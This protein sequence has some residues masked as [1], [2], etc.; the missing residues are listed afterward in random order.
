M[1]Q[2]VQ[3]AMSRLG[4][5]QTVTMRGRV[6]QV[7][8]LT[9]AACGP[10]A[11]LG[12]L[13]YLIPDP[14]RPGVPAE[15]VGFRDGLILLMP[16][17][18]VDGI[19]PGCE[20][21]ASGHA[22][23]VGV[24]AGLLGRVLDGLGR[25]AD[26]RGP[27]IAQARKETRNVP[28][29]PLERPMID[30]PLPSG[31]RVLDGLLTCGKGQRMG[32]FSGSG[33]GKST[34]LG[35][36]SR[37]KTADV[38][39]IALVGERGREVR[40]FLERDLGP[41]G[42]DRSVVVVATSDQPALVRIQAAYTATTIAEFFRDQGNDV[43]LLMDSV[44]RLAMALR[45]VGLAIGEPPATRGYTPSVFSTL[46][47]LFE[48]AGRSPQGSITGF[49]TV[50]IDGDDLTEPV[51]DA[52]RGL[53]DGHVLLSRDL[54]GRGLYPAV[55]LLGSVSRLMPAVTD[56]EHQAAAVRLKAL[57]STYRAAEDL[58]NVGAYVA[59]TN[60][61]ID[62]ACAIVPQIE[63]FIRQGVDE[64]A[65]FAETRDALLALASKAQPVPARDSAAVASDAAVALGGSG[66]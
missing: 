41:Q 48:R 27:V 33:V 10:A 61:E 60:P 40:E 8:G 66:A 53:L 12:E 25:P 21:I 22:F 16:L 42:L 3:G 17:G 34:L 38:S 20:V 46:P 35:M 24:G 52:M 18:S 37:N 30:E 11:C 58:I 23:R 43:I 36:V 56:R 44:T 54:A 26:G 39:V 64:R 15:V 65:S 63:A 4:Q 51:T 1:L 7:V 49:Y 47:K 31:I 62:V 6:R 29:H 2:V 5:A 57:V 50:L 9:I 59:G 14:E 28:P 13:C 55:D 45:E 32:I 19:A